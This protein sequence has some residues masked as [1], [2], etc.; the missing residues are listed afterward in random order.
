M[1]LGGGVG[2][3]K[4]LR[5]LARAAPPEDITVV[6]NTGDDL[7]LHGLHISPDID[8]VLYWLAGVADRERGWGRAGESFRTMDALRA[9]GGEA[10]FGLGDLDLATHLFRTHLMS[11]GATLSESTDS[12]RRALGIPC[13]VLPMTD[14]PVATRIEA[15]DEER[16]LRD[17]SFQE[18]W[19]ARG[20]RDDVKG[21]RYDGA[22]DASPAPG[23][24]EAIGAAEAVVVCPSNPVASIL[25]ILAVPGISE[26]VRAARARAVGISPI[27]R[28]APLR[29]MADRLM[30]AVGLE[31]SAGGAAAA[32]RGL[33]AG[34]VIDDLDADAAEGI[35]EDLDVRV[36]VTDTIMVDDAAAERVARAALDLVRT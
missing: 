8:S 29:G 21:V 16:R 18:Y 7:R 10:W 24:V 15:V 25:P 33:L 14:D 30:P 12:L 2:A 1:A 19:V 17:L 23:V 4:L 20:A 31:V 3:G 11:G 26:A 32:Y 5:G 27:V 22:A 28:G 13:A 34:W 35:E 9:L 36:A 6:V